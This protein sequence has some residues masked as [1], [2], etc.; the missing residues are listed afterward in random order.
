MSVGEVSAAESSVAAESVEALR[1]ALEEAALRLGED[2]RIERPLVLGG[3]ISQLQ[4]LRESGEQLTVRAT[5]S[6]S[7][8]EAESGRILVVLDGT[9][10]SR[11][12][13]PAGDVELRAVEA[14]VIRGAVDG[15]IRRLEPTL[16]NIL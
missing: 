13:A 1:G 15:A 5:V 4:H 8:S 12:A 16:E 3:S 11:G 7:L 2:P 10:Q 6:L 9:A 14:E